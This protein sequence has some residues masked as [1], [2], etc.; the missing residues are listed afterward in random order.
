MTAVGLSLAPAAGRRVFEQIRNDLV[1]AYVA[2]GLDDATALREASREAKRRIAAPKL[3]R[4]DNVPSVKD[5]L[6][7]LP[8]KLL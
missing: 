1:A 2:S 3:G 4:S 7:K 6:A 8:L 5:I